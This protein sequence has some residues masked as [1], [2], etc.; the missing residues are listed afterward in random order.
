LGTPGY[1]NNEGHP[2]PNAAQSAPFGGGSIRFFDLLKEWRGNGEFEGL[3]FGR[4]PG[5]GAG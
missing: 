2:N 1:D 5:S 4:P 3:A